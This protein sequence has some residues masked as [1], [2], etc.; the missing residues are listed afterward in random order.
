MIHAASVVANPD[1]VLSAIIS[2]RATHADSVGVTFHLSG[3][4]GTDSSAPAVALLEGEARIPVLGLLPSSDYVLRVVAYGG[5]HREVGDSLAF[6]TSALPADLPRFN[7]GGDDPSPGFVVFGT[8]LYGQVIDNTGRVVWYHRFPTGPGLNFMPQRNGR[9]VARPSLP[10]TS[11]REKFIEIDPLGNVTR[12]LGCLGGLRPRLHDL[13]SEP[14]GSYWIMCDE[15]RTMDL[16]SDGGVQNAQVTGTVI[17]H[18]GANGELLFQW[19][20]FDHFAITDLDPASRLGS[21]VNWTH[22]NAIDL[23]TDGN[24]IASFRSLNEVTKINVTTGNVLWRLGGNRNDFTFVDSPAPAFVRQHGVRAYAP[25]RLVLLDNMGNP[26]ESRAE[27]YVL[28]PE[29]KTARLVQSYGSVPGVMTPI[30]GSVQ[31]LPEAR[32]LVSFGT[33]GRVEEYDDAGR[34]LWR[35]EG[36]AGYV[37]RATRIASL[38]SPGVSGTR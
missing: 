23:D 27:R 29:L 34:I 18:I 26:V 17:Q 15:V 10:D 16:R 28:D 38:Y 20:P 36:N 6:S 19:S 5:S 4:T 12:M 1:N 25:G 35:I 8:A 3:A 13:I 22:G 2:T 21:A 33:M 31:H 14:A 7:A 11:V 9:Y 37:F 30:G 32:A 24:L